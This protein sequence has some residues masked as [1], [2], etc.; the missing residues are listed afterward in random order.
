MESRL[1]KLFAAIV[2]LLLV[3]SQ[4][5][6]A[7]DCLYSHP[8]SYFCNSEVVIRAKI[9]REA[10]RNN[11]V[12]GYEL[13][14]LEVFKGSLWLPGTI[15]LIDISTGASIDLRA[16]PGDFVLTGFGSGSLQVSGCSMVKPWSELTTK[17]AL[18]IRGAYKDGCSCEIISSFP[19]PRESKGRHCKLD[20]DSANQVANQ[21]CIPKG[22]TCSWQTIH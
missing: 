12:N 7:S 1:W 11:S 14:I 15:I 9:L 3:G 5:S 8:Q 19:K 16:D 2:L 6:S 20:D 18:G 10:E 17:Q 4:Q 13:Q 22:G 21:A